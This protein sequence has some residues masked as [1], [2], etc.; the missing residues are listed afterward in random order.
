MTA[1]M[2]KP[3]Y[4]SILIAIL[5]V[6]LVAPS[7]LPSGQASTDGS[8]DNIP[9][10][11]MDGANARHD[12]ITNQSLTIGEGAA[13][14]HMTLGG[15]TQALPA[16][17]ADGT[18][19]IAC[20]NSL[21]YAID[22]SGHIKWTR[23]VLQYNP[24][25]PA[26]GVDGTI[27]LASDGPGSTM[28][29]AIDPNGTTV[30]E[31]NPEDQI[32]DHDASIDFGSPIIL[33][34]NGTILVTGG[35]GGASS[36]LFAYSPNGSLLWSINEPHFLYTPAVGPEGNIYIGS[37]LGV[38][39]AIGPDGDSL[40]SLDLGLGR[41]S[42]GLFPSVGADGT[43]YFILSLYDP[44]N[45]QTLYSINPNGTI[46]WEFKPVGSG[47]GLPWYPISRP[48]IGREGTIYLNIGV[49]LSGQS[50]QG[51]PALMAIDPDGTM[52]WK[53]H[54][55]PASSTSMNSGIT[56]LVIDGQDMIIGIVGYN[57]FVVAANGTLQEEYA[58][59]GYFSGL[60]VGA[61]GTLYFVENGE[62]QLEVLWAYDGVPH[63]QIPPVPKVDDNTST[64]IIILAP[65][66]LVSLIVIILLRRR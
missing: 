46:N 63:S 59:P 41:E 47:N 22:T 14:W 61:N 12:G 34:S 33:T 7:F 62:N 28:L 1:M 17:G 43:I 26:V 53:C 52:Q 57:L 2:G 49:P 35:E 37:S 45:N 31:R 24:H 21:L 8:N 48:A 3:G 65:V 38:L 27:Y 29:Y 58:T 60:T 4:S 40:W 5:I 54:I 10:W 55:V 13:L 42:P 20:W 16:I 6:G 56:G 25:S 15:G 9:Y 64:V 19:Y 44:S 30:W 50:G 66:I 18:I 11:P 36:Y 51:F 39:Y 32:L 23:E